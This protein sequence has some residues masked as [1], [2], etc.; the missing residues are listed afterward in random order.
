MIQRRKLKMKE[1]VSI[2]YQSYFHEER[3]WGFVSKFILM[4]Y[5]KL[6]MLLERKFKIVLSESV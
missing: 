6:V 1:K 2:K 4:F 5:Y 3:K